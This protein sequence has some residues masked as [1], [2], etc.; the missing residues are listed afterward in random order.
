MSVVAKLVE[1]EPFGSSDVVSYTNDLCYVAAEL[2]LLVR[3]EK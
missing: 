3:E 2:A 1:H